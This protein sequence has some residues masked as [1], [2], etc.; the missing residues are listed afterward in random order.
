MSAAIRTMTAGLVLVSGL[1]AGAERTPR[2]AEPPV[3]H[4]A[5][6]IDET[7]L[8]LAKSSRLD[9]QLQVLAGLAPHA[10]KAARASR[11]P[12][13]DGRVRVRISADDPQ[14]ALGELEALGL[15]SAATRGRLITGWLPVAAL[16]AAAQVAS[17]RAIRPSHA[18]VRAGSVMSQGDGAQ[19]SNVARSTFGVNGAGV[20]VGILSDSYNCLAGANAGIASGDLPAAGVTV[21]KELSPC[22]DGIDEGRGMAE[23]VRDVAPGAR[24]LFRTAFDGEADFANGIRALRGAGADI[25]VDDI[26]YFSEPFFQDGEIAQAVEDVVADGAAYFSAAGNAAAESYRSAFVPSS[27]SY[28]DGSF[29]AFDPGSGRI[30]MRVLIPAGGAAAAILQWSDPF[31]SVSGGAGAASDVDLFLVDGAGNLLA[32]S[33]AD[34]LGGDPVEIIDWVNDGEVD[35]DGDGQADEFFF[36]RVGLFAGPQPDVIKIVAQDSMLVFSDYTGTEST[37]VGHPNARGAFSTG[38]ANYPDTPRFGTNPPL[39]A[40]Y[41]S[42]GGTPIL[43]RTSGSRISPPGNR[44]KPDAV[45]PSGANT[46][47]FGG[48][49]SDG[50]GFPNFF[51]TS[52]AAP[53]AAAAAALVLQAAGRSLSPDQIYRLL[54]T[55]AID[56]DEVGPDPRSGVGLIQ[57]NQAV[58]AALDSAAPDT[59][60]DAFDFRD[61]S[62]NRARFIYSNIVTLTGIDAPTTL[63]LTGSGSGRFIINGGAPQSGSATLNA[64]DTVRLRLTSKATPG[65]RSVTVDI[66]GV[67][68]RWTVTTVA[69][70]RPNAFD[71]IDR[72]VSGSAKVL[73]NTIT[74]GGINVPTTLT[75]SGNSSGRF[76][77][78]GGTPQSGTA[79]VGAGDTVRLQLTS[80]AT[81]GTRSVTVDIGGVTDRWSVTTE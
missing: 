37:I 69:D 74:L 20:T 2:N 71:F 59:T 14:R 12:V 68:D 40:G 42:L 61:K 21:L 25:L 23:I 70:S 64:G 58:G 57:V 30:Q 22:G 1:A 75:L 19:R 7:T 27:V 55:G 10:S 24:I 44:R 4:K 11:L 62:T 43:F 77:I 41:S 6:A 72:T 17:V 67:S 47:F 76:I 33:I 31:F 8:G 60:P 29:H 26:G 63:T 56:M 46:T 9:P 15:A 48:E 78:N 65:T 66:G 28:G 51:G 36:L 5:L 35:A 39:L 38:A 45:A 73:S 34:N 32:Q 13:V 16:S 79:T 50:D 53:H 49:D 52:A 81:P 3:M 80:R 18:R 54:K